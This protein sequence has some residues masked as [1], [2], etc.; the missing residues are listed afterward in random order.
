MIVRIVV[1]NV[2]IYYIRTIQWL[3]FSRSSELQYQMFAYI[4]FVLADC[5]ND[6]DIFRNKL[7]FVILLKKN[8]KKNIK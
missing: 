6:D 4:V 7:D 2:C 1:S 5:Q 8:I 3:C